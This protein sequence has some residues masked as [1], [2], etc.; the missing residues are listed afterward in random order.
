VTL[1]LFGVLVAIVGGIIAIT[2]AL[3]L[4]LTT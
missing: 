3:K 1:Q 2:L 4:F